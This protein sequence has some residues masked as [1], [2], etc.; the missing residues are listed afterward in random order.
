MACA[1]IPIP[2]SS[3]RFSR[4]NEHLEKLKEKYSYGFWEAVD[5][6]HSAVRFCTKL[7]DKERSSRCADCGYRGFIGC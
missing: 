3:S 2:T 5:D 4:M 7:G 6:S 1:M